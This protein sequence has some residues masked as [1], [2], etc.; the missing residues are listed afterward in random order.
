LLFEANPGKQFMTINLKKHPAQKRAGGVAQVAE[1]LTSKN[2]AL[3]S[4]SSTDKK[5]TLKLIRM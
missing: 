2:E 4:N 3:S 5:F 1:C